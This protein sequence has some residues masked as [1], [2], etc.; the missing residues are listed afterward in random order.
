MRDERAC[1]RGES[2]VKSPVK[3]LLTLSTQTA[4]KKR[5][6]ANKIKISGY[7]IATLSPLA[8]AL[9]RAVRVVRAAGKISLQNIK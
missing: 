3:F 5:N 6:Y 8:G 1:E 4:T 9:V 2:Q 7:K